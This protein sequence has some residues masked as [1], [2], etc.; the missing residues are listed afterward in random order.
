MTKILSNGGNGYQE[1][2]GV[3]SFYNKI[4]RVE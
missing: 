3:S 4:Q 2:K 1:S